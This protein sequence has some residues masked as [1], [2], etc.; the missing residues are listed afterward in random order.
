VNNSNSDH[1][2]NSPWTV[3]GTLTSG[4]QRENK[5]NS[6]LEKPISGKID[7]KDI[8]LAGVFSLDRVAGLIYITLLPVALT[9]RLRACS[10]VG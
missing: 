4:S 5:D 1:L 6:V 8:D 9:F 7:G 3:G 2:I 10:S